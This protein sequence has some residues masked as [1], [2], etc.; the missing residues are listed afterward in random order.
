MQQTNGIVGLRHNKTLMQLS[1][2]TI[3]KD[4]RQ[5][6]ER[7][8]H[9][10]IHQ[11]VWRD[12]TEYSRNVE[13]IIVDGAS[14]DRSVDVIRSYEASI[15][16]WISETDKGV[17]EAM[18]KGV[19]MARGEW[20]LFMNAGDELYSVDTIE[21]LFCESDIWTADL[22]VGRA[23]M[24]RDGRQLSV[25]MP[26]RELTTG[27]LLAASIIHQAALMRTAL[28]REHPYDERLRIVADWKHMLEQH[29]SRR[30]YAYTTTTVII[31][32]F[33]TTGISSNTARRLA[34]RDVVLRELLPPAVYDEYKSREPLRVLWNTP[35]LLDALT[36]ACRYR[37]LVKW[38]TCALS[39]VVRLYR[40]GKRLLSSL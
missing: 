40:L 18:N 11:T 2:I 9:S 1:I 38:L 5:G 27:W 6:L 14:T 23:S 10:V 33:D 8:I 24:V 36:E 26:P 16:R 7:T 32:R 4:D 17:Y 12:D 22:I 29:L 37:H 28:L 15:T 21:K 35:R 25:V 3:C 30:T 39:M 31:C 13:Y 20:C 34:E 19:A